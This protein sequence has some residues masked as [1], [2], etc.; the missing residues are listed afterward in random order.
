MKEKKSILEPQIE[1]E[2]H[3]IGI[4]LTLIESIA[5]VMECS[6][7]D[8]YDINQV[9]IANLLIVMKRLIKIVIDKYDKIE[10]CLNI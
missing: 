8:E 9:D 4:D 6:I 5:N 3:D 10:C 1:E 7:N 2:L